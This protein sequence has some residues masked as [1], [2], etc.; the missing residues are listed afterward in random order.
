MIPIQRTYRQNTED[1]L[2]KFIALGHEPVSNCASDCCYR[3]ARCD[4]ELID[5][6]RIEHS[7]E[8]QCL[9]AKATA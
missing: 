2:E 8:K 5:D 4:E 7:L 1:A 6:Y 3:C 9:H